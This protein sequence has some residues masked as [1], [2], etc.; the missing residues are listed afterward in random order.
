MTTI[1]GIHVIVGVGRAKTRGRRFTHFDVGLLECRNALG[2]HVHFAEP[3]KE[4]GAA[5][6][7][8]KPDRLALLNLRSWPCVSLAG[9]QPRVSL[10]IRFAAGLHEDQKI[11]V[12]QDCIEFRNMSDKLSVK[13]T[14]NMLS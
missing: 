11:A 6:A 8:L 7:D 10:Y 4:A 5:A 3:A 1:L 14:K 12:L 13:K 2:Q 9:L